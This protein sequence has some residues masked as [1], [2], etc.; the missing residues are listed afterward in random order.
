MKEKRKH[1]ND[2]TE[3]GQQKYREIRRMSERER[4]IHGRKV[5]GIE[6]WKEYI[7]DLYNDEE[8]ELGILKETSQEDERDDTITR[9][10]YE[11]TVADLNNDKAPGVDRI[12]AEIIK[13]IGEA[14]H[15]ILHALINEMYK[16]EKVPEDFKKNIIIP[17]SKKK[18]KALNAKTIGQ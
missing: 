8:K 7:E 4:S 2:T 12:P 6:I 5:S 10:E 14:N 3:I 9:S 16:S 18:E 1:I 11:R 15:E 13:Q 17:F